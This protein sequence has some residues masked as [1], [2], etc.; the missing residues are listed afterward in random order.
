LKL[1]I[2]FTNSVLKFEYPLWSADS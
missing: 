1:Y 2:F